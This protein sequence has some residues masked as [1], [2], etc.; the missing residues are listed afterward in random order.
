MNMYELFVSITQLVRDNNPNLV[1]H[2]NKK[3]MS[4]DV[5]ANDE[6]IFNLVD[7]STIKM[8]VKRLAQI[9]KEQE[10]GN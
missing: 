5:T 10:K 2:K 4:I 8:K 3:I 1:I 6:M 9:I 7:N